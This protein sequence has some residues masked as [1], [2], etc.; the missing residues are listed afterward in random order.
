L[1]V[2]FF[3]IC[4]YLSSVKTTSIMQH[5][6]QTYCYRYRLTTAVR[7]VNR[8]PDNYWKSSKIVSKT[9]STRTGSWTLEQNSVYSRFTV[10]NSETF[11]DLSFTLN[12]F[13]HSLIFR[14]FHATNASLVNS[15]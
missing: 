8:W 5:Q 4:L 3:I 14:N 13:L 12:S 7:Y 1:F 10:T 11:N 2:P 6:N 9:N 15:S